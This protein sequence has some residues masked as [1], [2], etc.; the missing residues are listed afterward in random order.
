MK[1]KEEEEGEEE[2]E[3]E[4]EENRKGKKGCRLGGETAT[5]ITFGRPVFL[6]SPPRFPRPRSPLPL[7]A[8][9][10]SS[11]TSFPPR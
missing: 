1:E 3:E 5:G 7:C 11:P 4:E 8:L 9:P 10:R 6:S 2:E